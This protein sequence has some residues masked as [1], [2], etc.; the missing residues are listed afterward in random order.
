MLQLESFFRAFVSVS[1]LLQSVSLSAKEDCH[2]II[3]EITATSRQPLLQ[4][5]ALLLGQGLTL[6]Q[7]LLQS[8]LRINLVQVL[9]CSSSRHYNKNPLLHILEQQTLTLYNHH[10]VYMLL[11]LAT[12]KAVLITRPLHIQRLLHHTLKLRLQLRPLSSLSTPP[13]FSNKP[14]LQPKASSLLCSHSMLHHS[15]TLPLTFLARQSTQVIHLTP[16]L[17]RQHLIQLGIQIKTILHRQT[18]T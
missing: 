14:L 3:T 6:Q 10:L 11:P 13:R 1:V 16:L 15:P 9:L 18:D 4:R 8:L 17:R 7:L 2:Q 12:H 5:Q